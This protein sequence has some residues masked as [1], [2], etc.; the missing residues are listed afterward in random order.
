ML[1][2]VLG[3]KKHSRLRVR[4]YVLYVIMRKVVQ[5][6]HYGGAIS[7]CSHKHDYP[8]RT[9]APYQSYLVAT[10]YPDVFHQQVKSRYLCRHV[11]V[12][13]RTATFAVVCQCR[14]VEIVSP[15]ILI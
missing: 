7:H 5:N 11:S 4:N 9:I 6:R 14:Q 3:R 2:Y 15:S 12:S 1:I 8:G 10:A 13:E